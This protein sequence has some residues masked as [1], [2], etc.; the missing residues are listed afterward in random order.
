MAEDVRQER[1]GWSVLGGLE[2]GLEQRGLAA[3]PALTIIE[4]QHRCTE[5]VERDSRFAHCNFRRIA[6]L[7]H[8]RANGGEIVGRKR[9]SALR[10][11]IFP[12]CAV[13]ASWRAIDLEIVRHKAGDATDRGHKRA[14][15]SCLS[16]DPDLRPAARI[17]ETLGHAA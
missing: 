13:Q 12:F 6:Q 4:A 1:R 8:Q 3:N 10:T 9:A 17:V 7:L 11:R 2:A 14:R 16:L 15:C 5:A